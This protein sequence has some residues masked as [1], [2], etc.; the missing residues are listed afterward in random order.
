MEEREPGARV[1]GSVWGLASCKAVQTKPLPSR[2]DSVLRRVVPKESQMVSRLDNKDDA[3]NSLL[4]ACVVSV[5]T[6]KDLIKTA[7]KL[8]QRYIRCEDLNHLFFRAD[9]SSIEGRLLKGLHVTAITKCIKM[10]FR[11]IE[12]DSLHECLDP[13]VIQPPG[14]V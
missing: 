3:S 4:H 9:L 6:A 12:T 7:C 1:S 14:H 5:T 8:H 2:P 13:R 10:H 11:R